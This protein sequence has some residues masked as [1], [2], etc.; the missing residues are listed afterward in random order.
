MKKLIKK[1]KTLNNFVLLFRHKKKWLITNSTTIYKY[2]KQKKMY[3]FGLKL[4]IK[5]FITEFIFLKEKNESAKEMGY[6]LNDKKL[7]E[8]LLL[9]KHYKDTYKFDFMDAFSANINT[10]DRYLLKFN[11]KN[12]NINYLEIGSFEGRSSVFIL[13]RLESATCTFVDPFD[14]YDEMFS[15][16]GQDDFEQVYIN[17]LQNIKKFEGRYKVFRK[18]SNAFF[19]TN[20]QYFDFIYIDGSHFGED[21]YKDACNSFE[22]LNKDGY[23]IFDDIFFNH[24]DS[25]EENVLGGVVKF[26]IEKK[27]NIRI[28]YLSNQ[29]VVRKI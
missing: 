24:F 1:F 10:W 28:K 23:I 17:F 14:P 20:K 22:F 15:S 2:F 21:V 16:T 5:M 11:L 8:N 4:L 12:K 26:L 27:N 29:L 19:S 7:S 18:K 9:E 6:V 13:E 25:M 3:L